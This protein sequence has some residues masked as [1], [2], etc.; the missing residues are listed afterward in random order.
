MSNT[1]ITFLSF[2][3]CSFQSYLHVPK[4]WNWAVS[5]QFPIFSS[6][7]SGSYECH[8]IQCLQTGRSST[9]P[10]REI[11]ITQSETQAHA[12][13]LQGIP[14]D[15][16]PMNLEWHPPLW[17]TRRECPEITNKVGA[18]AVSVCVTAGHT[19]SSGGKAFGDCTIIMVFLGRL[20]RLRKG[21]IRVDWEAKKWGKIE[22]TG[23]TRGLFGLNSQQ[24]CTLLCVHSYALCLVPAAG[25]DFSL[26]SISTSLPGW[27]TL[28]AYLCVSV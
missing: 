10:K 28:H 24:S 18:R 5:L 12:L 14:G 7:F 8:L 6:S 19:G 22:W 3:Y 25:S 27:V 20:Q 16:N 15:T 17:A 2:R 11:S 13:V 1:L 21:G 26:N 9:V 4:D 23:C